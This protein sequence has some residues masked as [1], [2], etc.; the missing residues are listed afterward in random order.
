MSTDSAAVVC[1]G[2]HVL[3][4]TRIFT[5]GGLDVPGMKVASSMPRVSEGLVVSQESREM[6]LGLMQPVV[7]AT[8]DR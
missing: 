8:I 2:Q 7:M 3:R 1:D 6:V 4:D 5:A